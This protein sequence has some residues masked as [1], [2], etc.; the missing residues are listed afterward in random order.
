MKLIDVTFIHLMLDLTKTIF[1]MQNVEL[2]C[3]FY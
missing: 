2:G 3:E 1:S